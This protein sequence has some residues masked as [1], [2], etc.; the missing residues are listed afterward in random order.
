[1]EFVQ[2]IWRD[3]FQQ[4]TFSFE[5]RDVI[6]VLPKEETRSGKWLLK[7]EYFGAYQDM[8]EYF[9]RKGYVIAFVTNR[10]RWGA[11]ID[12]DLKK[13]FCDF[14]IQEFNLDKKCI[15]IGMSCGGLI[16]IKFAAKYPEC[17]RAL[18]LDAP[19]VNLLS[20]P[21]GMG[22][23]TDLPPENVGIALRELDMNNISDMLAYRNHPLDN[24][25]ALLTHK[26]PV[27]LV[28]GDVDETVIYEE[29]GLL[30]K[31]AYEN[32]DIPFKFMLKAGVG[33]HPHGPDA[34]HI[35]AFFDYLDSF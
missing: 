33:H 31:Q 15:P 21:C 9:V 24:I 32:S 29:N 19:V 12:L 7:T 35:P 23:G 4:L 8:E 20:C 27:A 14:M 5:G 34:E 28:C 10:D 22:K 3:E 17:V 6:I 11:E 25:P 18:Y 13:R 2:S 30:V 16:G 1:M 26:I